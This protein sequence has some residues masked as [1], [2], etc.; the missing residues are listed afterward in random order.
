[1]NDLITQK[2]ALRQNA[3]VYPK[4]DFLLKLFIAADKMGMVS[5]EEDVENKLSLR[6]AWYV[7][8]RVGEER[9][10]EYRS[11]RNVMYIMELYFTSYE[12]KNSGYTWLD[13]LKIIDQNQKGI[14]NIVHK[15]E[16]YLE[17]RLKK[18]RIK[19]GIIKRKI[20][21]IPVAYGYSNVIRNIE[22]AYTPYISYISAKTFLYDCNVIISTHQRPLFTK[23]N[24]GFNSILKITNDLAKEL[25]ILELFKVDDI[26][27]LVLKYL[28]QTEQRSF[29]G[30]L[31]ELVIT[32]YLFANLYSDNPKALVIDKV[33]AKLILSEIMSDRLIA[34]ELIAIGIENLEVPKCKSDY[35]K[36][37]ETILAEKIKGIKEK[38]TI[39]EYF[40][41]TF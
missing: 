38:K 8:K 41:V 3:V 34:K 18:L 2:E 29:E 26:N 15:S 22:L 11:I 1:M 37:V 40:V 12:F 6:L 10:D 39:A 16:E 24:I 4:G 9:Y 19:L 7:N 31:F 5:S 14:T 36:Q 30:N 20:L 32:N 28:E 33:D 23:E 35:I 25:D 17:K 27:N 21:K 13:I